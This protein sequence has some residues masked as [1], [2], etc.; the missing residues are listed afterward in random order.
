MIDDTTSDLQEH[1]ESINEKLEALQHQALKSS[2]QDNP[3]RQM[4][5]EEKYS[6]QKCLEICAEV[7]LHISKVQPGVFQDISTPSRGNQGPISS[8]NGLILARS[9]TSD[10]LE[11]CKGTLTIT[12]SKLESHLQDIENR[13]Q[14]LYSASSNLSDE[15]QTERDRIQEEL[16]ST[17]QGLAICAEASEKAVEERV[18]ILEDVSLAENGHQV[19]VSTI[20]DLILA[21]RVTAGRGSTQWMGQMS[22]ASLQH[23]T[24]TLSQSALEVVSDTQYGVDSKF[25][26]RYGTGI[27]LD[28]SKP[29][30]SRSI[31]K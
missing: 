18:N 30:I 6:T 16:N 19:I 31:S 7:T 25:E 3:E 11:L 29:N 20:G 22:D 26:G 1:L 24:T 9:T 27:K 13:L 5:E 28:E 21:K 12:T 23:L 15:Q 4:M 14:A 17:K 8:L 2:T 10:T